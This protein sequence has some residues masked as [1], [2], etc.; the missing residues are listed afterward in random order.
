MGMGAAGSGPGSARRI[1][2]F[3]AVVRKRNIVEVLLPESAAGLAASPVVPDQFMGLG[4]IGFGGDHAISA[5]VRGDEFILSLDGADE[6]ARE[7]LEFFACK[8]FHD[9]VLASGVHIN[10]WKVAGGTLTVQ[11]AMGGSG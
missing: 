1:F 9:L 5:E 10:W 7:G 2:R 8:I 3:F 11:I 4:E 6:V